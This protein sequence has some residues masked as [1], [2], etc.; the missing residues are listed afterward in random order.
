[1][2]MQLSGGIVMS[3][4]EKVEEKESG[5]RPFIEPGWYKDLGN[6]EYHGSFGV[7]SSQLKTL[8]EQTPAHL[9][10]QMGHPKESTA[11][12]ALGTAVHSLVLE[13][14]QFDADI[15]VA[16]LV[17]KRTNA[18]KQEWS[19]FVASSGDKAVITEVQYEQ[20]KLMAESVRNHPIAGRLLED[21]VPESSVYWWYRSMDADDD[22]KYKQLLKVRPDALSRAYP[23]VMDLKTTADGSYS[24]FV[25]SIQNFNYHV[26]AAMYLEGINQCKPLLEEMRHFAYTK[27]IFICVENFPP[28]LT[29]AYDLSPEYLD[30]GKTL[31]RRSLRT[32]RDGQENDWPG[33]PDEV[34]I[35]EPPGWANRM[36]IV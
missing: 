35:I 23:V 19:D 1:M 12:M 18:G 4:A 24:G 33:Y 10:Y 17:N 16:P 20:A 9:L 22:T 29:S 34:R 6:E 3:V 26:S 36:H 8:I 31:Y 25:K 21:I 30:I 14:G 15:A 32:L 27:F 2:K 13:P 11:N 7:S 5:K 28:Y